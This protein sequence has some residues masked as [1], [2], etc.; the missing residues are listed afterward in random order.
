[1]PAARLFGRAWRFATDDLPLPAAIG[2]IVRAGWIGVF[3]AVW[4]SFLTPE[5]FASFR[6]MC[7]QD[8]FFP[9]EVST[10]KCI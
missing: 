1:M 5:A 3:V 7:V 4:I 2:S 6:G 10:T 9:V 8:P